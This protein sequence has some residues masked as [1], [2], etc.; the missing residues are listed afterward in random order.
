MDRQFPQQMIGPLTCPDLEQAVDILRQA[1]TLS[2]AEA[3][4][5]RPQQE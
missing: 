4:A 3:T 5:A 1:R 2:L